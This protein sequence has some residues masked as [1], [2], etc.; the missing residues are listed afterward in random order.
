MVQ[1][2]IEGTGLPGNSCGPSPERP[3]GHAGIHVGVQRRGKPA[4]LLGVTPG[5]ASVATWTLDAVVTPKPDGPADVRGLYIQGPPGG[6]F[7]YL[8]W[9]TV[10]DSGA[11]TMFRRAKLWLEAVP[12]EVLGSAADLGML[13]GRLGLVDPKGNPICASVRPPLIEWSAATE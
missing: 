10:D 1:I 8:N 11:F 2:R 3:V 13:V 5:G 12:P 6:R 4:E 9:G 7:I